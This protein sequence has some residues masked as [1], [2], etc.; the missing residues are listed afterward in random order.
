VAVILL[1]AFGGIDGVRTSHEFG[2]GAVL[3][4]VERVTE[5]SPA[6]RVAG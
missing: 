3:G 5:I 1:R 2:E 4:M 6:V